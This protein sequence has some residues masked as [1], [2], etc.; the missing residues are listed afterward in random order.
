MPELT[1]ERKHEI[2]MDLLE[3]ITD[4]IHDEFYEQVQCLTDEEQDW[5]RQKLDLDF[6]IREF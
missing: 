5:A 6:T 3:A 2:K 1:E 4:R